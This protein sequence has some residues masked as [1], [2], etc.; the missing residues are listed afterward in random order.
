MVFSK[1]LESAAWPNSRIVRGDGR[2]EVE[3]LKKLTGKDM[4]LGGEP[5]LAQSFLAQ[6]LVDELLL[7]VFPRLVRSSRPL[8]QTMTDPHP[9]GNGVPLGAPGRHDFKL[10]E[11]KP[12]KDGTV[13][14]HYRRSR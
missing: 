8:F 9:T 13:F 5:R 7:E 3:R 14:L 12:L 1:T 2:D 6:D 10:L 11:S 4:A